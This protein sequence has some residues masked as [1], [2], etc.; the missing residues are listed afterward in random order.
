MNIE[1][2]AVTF[3]FR[4]GGLRNSPSG[5]TYKCAK[6][7]LQGEQVAVDGRRVILWD[8]REFPH[9][10]QECGHCSG[11]HPDCLAK[12]ANTVAMGKSVQLTKA[13]LLRNN[14]CIAAKARP[15][16]YIQHVSRLGLT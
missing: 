12:I 16:L 13:N 2:A 10:K 4:S 14:F 15:G 1:Q 9:C 7:F 3:E 5:R 8:C 11:H 6:E